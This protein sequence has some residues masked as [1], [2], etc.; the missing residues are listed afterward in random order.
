MTTRVTTAMVLSQEN[1]EFIER[2]ESDETRKYLGWMAAL[3]EQSLNEGI[4]YIILFGF[5]FDPAAGLFIREVISTMTEET[6]NRE[7]RW[8][9]PGKLGF[10]PVF[11]LDQAEG[12]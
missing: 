11:P 1:L 7:Y 12:N 5:K 2:F 8:L 9:E 4:R 10:T 3:L 6:F